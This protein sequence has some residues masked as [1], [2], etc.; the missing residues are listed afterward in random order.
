ML[1]PEHPIHKKHQH[2]NVQPMQ[3]SS[4]DKSLGTGRVVPDSSTQT[5]QSTKRNTNQANKNVNLPSPGMPQ[6]FQNCCR[7]S[8]S[9]TSSGN[10]MP[11]YHTTPWHTAVKLAPNYRYRHACCRCGR[12]VQSTRMQCVCL[13]SLTQCYWLTQDAFCYLAQLSSAHCFDFATQHSAAQANVRP[14]HGLEEPR[15]RHWT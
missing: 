3:D 2:S 14:L 10:T 13:I 1:Q 4:S 12:L 9:D 6:L 15:V 5:R 11:T 7:D 8:G